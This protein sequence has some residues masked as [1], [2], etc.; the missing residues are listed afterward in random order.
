MS[1]PNTA[2]RCSVVSA[3]AMVGRALWIAVVASSVGCASTMRTPK[4]VGTKTGTKVAVNVNQVRLKMRSLVG[5][6]CGEIERAADQI[7]AET[8]DPAVRRAAIRWKIEAVPALSAALF[9]PEPFTALADAWAFSYQ[10]ADFFETGAGKK[11]LGDSAPVAV[12]TGRR[13]EQEIADVA[14]AMTVAGDV[15]KVRAVVKRWAAE[16][17]IR[18]A[19]PDRETALGR[20]LERDAPDSWS[21]GEAV[22]E[23]TTSVD[24]LNRKVDVYSDHLFRQVRWETELLG[25]DLRLGDLPPLAERAVQSAERASATLDRLAPGFE[26]AVTVAEKT[27]AIVASERKAAIDGLGEQLT[28]T[29]TFLQQERIA[30]LNHITAERIAAIGGLGERLAEERKVFDQDLERT[31]IELVDHAV[32]RLAQLAAAVLASLGVGI[33]AILVLVRKLFFTPLR[34]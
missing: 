32:W 33:V 7:A 22:A 1:K 26:R 8:D 30:A 15:S 23:I 18:Y 24:D 5:P 34:A 12:E 2:S 31:G 4:G 11:Q 27:P 13:L 9:Q 19:M 14:A 10:M 25:G 16:H 20:V 21:T 6:L 17:P 3:Q 29:I 28:R